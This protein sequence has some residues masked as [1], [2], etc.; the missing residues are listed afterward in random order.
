M[1]TTRSWNAACCRCCT[2]TTRC[3]EAV[4]DAAEID[5]IHRLLDQRVDGLI[6]WPSDET[7]SD[8]YLKEVWE[9]SIPLVAVDRHLP[10]TKADFSGTDD[11]AGGRIAA[12]HL[13]ALGHRHLAH[14]GGEAWVS[15]YADRRRGFEQA[16]AARGLVA[17]TVD[18]HG[19]D[20][21]HTVRP[22]LESADR[23]T[24]I[25]TASDLM[26]PGIYRAATECGL[27]V[28]RD[29]AVVGFADLP[30]ICGF[31]PGLSTLRQDPY[32]I[33]WHAVRLLLDRI[34]G[35]A[36]NAKPRTSRLVPQLIVR[37]SSS[38][39]HDAGSAIP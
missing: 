7:V 10:Q 19:C 27:A 25:F 34:E 16:I 3:A 2:S 33:G 36:N 12:E 20:S 37:A 21:Y 8:T 38:P 5:F 17:T 31:L 26:A 29:L 18:C 15:T 28:G 22:L 24:A 14:V 6:F 39:P 32:R 35:V 1:S 23:P 4:R 13:L 9:R 30:E 11:V